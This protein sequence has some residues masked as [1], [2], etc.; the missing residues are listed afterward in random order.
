ML[1][2]IAMTLSLITVITVQLVLN[3]FSINGKTTIEIVNRLPILFTPPS[4]VFGIWLLIYGFL[5]V[6]LFGFWRNQRQRSNATLN[7]RATLFISSVSLTILWLLLW[8]YEYFYWTV[9]VMIALLVTLA[10]LYFTYPKVENHIFERVPISIYFGWVIISFLEL[11]NYVLTFHEWG[12]WGLSN[13][14]WTVIFLTIT[15]SIALHFM[16]HHQDL[17]LNAVFIWV[18]IGIVVKN[19]FDSLFV[20]IAAL[21]LTFVIGASFFLIKTIDVALE[22][23]ASQK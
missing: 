11:I 22:S 15:T 20:S 16:Y 13:S 23:P 5:V 3:V 14:L 12:G 6:W 19:G 2:L 4:Y 9:I 18:F 7:Y 1:R 21:F 8:Q 10:R 17:S